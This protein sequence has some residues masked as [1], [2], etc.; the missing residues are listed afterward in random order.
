MRK[1]KFWLKNCYHKK[2]AKKQ[3]RGEKLVYKL[4]TW[5]CIKNMRGA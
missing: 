1:T 3:K 4:Y 5:G 2:Q